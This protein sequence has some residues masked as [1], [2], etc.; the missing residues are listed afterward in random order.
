[1][2]GVRR[3]GA[4]ARK[5]DRFLSWLSTIKHCYRFYAALLMRIFPSMKYVVCF[6]IWVLMS[7]YEA[8]IISSRRKELR[9]FS[10]FSP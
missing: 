4:V 9:K 7:E 5:Y 8:A 10:I 6:G 2:P 3:R 1:M